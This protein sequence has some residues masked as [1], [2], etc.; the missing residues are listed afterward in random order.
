MSR[1][2]ESSLLEDD[3]CVTGRP[4]SETAFDETM[5]ASYFRV[6]TCST[7]SRALDNVLVPYLPTSQLTARRADAMALFKQVGLGD[8]LD[9][10]PQQLSGEN[11]S[12]SPL[13]GLCSSDRNWS[14]P[15]NRP[16][17]WTA[18]P[19]GKSSVT[20]VI[21]IGNSEP[22]WSSSPTISGTSIRMTTFWKSGTVSSLLH[23]SSE[24]W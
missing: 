5:S 14:W 15:M 24:R 20:C 1:L 11:S 3:H 23:L 16:G 17:S 19:D 2:R 7:I 18:K 10:R 4:S 13:R 6:S 21:F 12:E 9:H 8:R 22:R